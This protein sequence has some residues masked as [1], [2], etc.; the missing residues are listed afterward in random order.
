LKDFC[1]VGSAGEELKISLSF[2]IRKTMREDLTLFELF[3][4]LAHWPI[5][6]G[7]FDILVAFCNKYITIFYILLTKECFNHDESLRNLIKEKTSIGR[8]KV[9]N[10]KRGPKSKKEIASKSESKRPKTPK[11]NKRD[12]PKKRQ[13]SKLCS[14]PLKG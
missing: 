3:G 5:Y 12:P 10:K 6:P 8:W 4:L 1:D 11:E 14:K 7:E 13:K 2:R 9:R